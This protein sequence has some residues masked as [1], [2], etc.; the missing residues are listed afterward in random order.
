[1][2]TA[3]KHNYWK[4]TCTLNW[5]IFGSSF[6]EWERLIFS[7]SSNCWGEY[8]HCYT[9]ILQLES[10]WQL[11][12]ISNTKYAGKQNCSWWNGVFP[13]VRNLSRVFA[14]LKTWSASNLGYWSSVFSCWFTNCTRI[15]LSLIVR[16]VPGTY[17][18]IRIK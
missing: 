11:N 15:K 1:M 18:P 16:I 13:D 14:V 10:S 2:R 8:V 9:A 7:F 3:F 5:C 17:C 4:N 12:T 6:W